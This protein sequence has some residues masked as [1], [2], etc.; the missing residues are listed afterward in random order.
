MILGD[1]SYQRLSGEMRF[2]NDEK[3]LAYVREIGDRLIRHLPPTGL[4][5]QFFIID[6]A[7]MLSSLPA[8]RFFFHAN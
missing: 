4:K 3:L 6:Q 1:L 2:V 8:D 7:R 5:F